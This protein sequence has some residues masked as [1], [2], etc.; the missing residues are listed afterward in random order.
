MEMNSPTVTGLEGGS[1]GTQSLSPSYTL[2]TT[3]A[4]AHCAAGFAA[5]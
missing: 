4:E 5:G 3:S 1:P 2:S